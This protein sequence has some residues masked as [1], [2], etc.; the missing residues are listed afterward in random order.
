MNQFPWAVL[1]IA[2]SSALLW[3]CSQPSDSHNYTVENVEVIFAG[4]L[5]EGA[6]TG[7]IP[8]EIDLAGVLG[9]AYQPG[10]KVTGAHL[11]EAEVLA[12]D[13]TGF[14]DVRSFVLSFACDNANVPMQEAAF[15]NPLPVDLDRV[16]LEVAPEAP[17]D[18]LVAEE[19]VY[20]IL[21]ADLASDYFDGDR[22]F[23]VNLT[24]SIQ[25]Q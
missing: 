9:E 3:S 15:I 14:A 19:K 18:K 20:L 25:L 5:L 21:D 16:K 11:V 4:P 23:L 12:G 1:A 10:M 8:L 6:N 7:Q 24:L 17:L 2:A 13:S 22:R